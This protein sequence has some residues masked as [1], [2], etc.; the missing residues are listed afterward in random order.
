[1]FNLDQKITE[2]RRRMAADGIRNPAVLDELESHLREDV[3]RE[4]KSG[5]GDAK[6]FETAARRLGQ[7]SLLKAEFAKINR[8]K[9]SRP[10]QIIGIA[11]CAL[12]G[13]VVS[14]VSP[15]FLTI[16][17]MTLGQRLT[18]FAAVGVAVFAIMSWR[19]SYRYL[20]VIRHPWLRMAVGLACGL[21][22]VVW[23]YAF[24]GLLY[25]VI[26]PRAFNSGT[27]PQNAFPAFN[28]FL[29]FVWAIAFAAVLGGL[30]YGLEEAARRQERKETHV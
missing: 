1:M 16:R 25:Y 20:P 12:A 7:S 10:A 8:F 29:A 3:E 19:F 2:W 26:V 4:M 30:A 28:I 18:G 21:A 5:S 13:I 14:W 22:G 24:G 17:E 27:S 15:A 6:A 9:W 11:L 23:L